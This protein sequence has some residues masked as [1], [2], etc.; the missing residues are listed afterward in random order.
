ML[1]HPPLLPS[2]SSSRT[3]AEPLPACATLS[4]GEK[5]PANAKVLHF[6]GEHGKVAPFGPQ[7]ITEYRFALPN[8]VASLY[9]YVLIAFPALCY[10]MSNG[11]IYRFNTTAVW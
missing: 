11:F 9:M 4:A 6:H 8:Q 1:D 3:L 5:E 10:S 2:S 7:G